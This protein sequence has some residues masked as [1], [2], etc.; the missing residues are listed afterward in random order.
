MTVGLPQPKQ[1]AGELGLGDTDKGLRLRFGKA[2][3]EVFDPHPRVDQ[4][5]HG[6]DLEQGEGQGEEFETGRHHQHRAH[7]AAD[8]DRLEGQR[9][10]AAFPVEFGESVLVVAGLLPAVPAGRDE[11]RRG[12]RLPARH[13]RQVRGNIGRCSLAH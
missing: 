9:H 8:A 3:F 2:G 11:D 1:D 7:P 6:T 5:R 13:L 10:A 12:V 4:D